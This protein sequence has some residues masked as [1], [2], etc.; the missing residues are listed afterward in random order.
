MWESCI[1]WHFSPIYHK[2]EFVTKSRCE[3]LKGQTICL[4]WLE[5]GPLTFSNCNCKMT[6]QKHNGILAKVI[7]SCGSHSLSREEDNL[8]IHS[9]SLLLLQKA[10]VVWNPSCWIEKCLQGSKKLAW[11]CIWKGVVLTRKT[12]AWSKFKTWLNE[13]ELRLSLNGSCFELQHHLKRGLMT[14]WSGKCMQVETHLPVVSPKL[15]TQHEK[16]PSSAY[17]LSSCNARPSPGWCF[18]DSK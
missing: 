1:V 15:W 12:L 5:N 10:N 9:H 4:C 17:N 7:P 13:N 11:L 3:F 2:S 6:D 8:R 18:K 14:I 16:L